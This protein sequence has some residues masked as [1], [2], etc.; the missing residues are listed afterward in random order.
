MLISPTML[1]LLL[2]IGF[3][4]V[5]AVRQSLYSR[6]EGVDESGFV[7]EGDKFVGMV[8][9]TDIF[10]GSTGDAFWNAFYVTTM[11]TVV[12]VVIEVIIGVAMALIMN[13]AFKGRGLIRASILVPWAIPTAVS[14][15]LWQWIFDAN[16]IANQILNTQVLWST[17]GIQAQ[18]AVIIA[19]TWKTAPFIGLLTL[20]G[21]Q[22]IPHEVYEAAKLDGVGAFKQFRHITLPLVKPALMVAILFRILD[23][24]RMFD[25]PYVLIGRGKTSVETLSILAY[26]E[27]S[28][29]DFGPASAYAV[30]LFLY[31]ALVAYAFV[32]LLGADV[33]GDA[34]ETKKVAKA[35]RKRVGGVAKGDMP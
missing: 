35:K 11:F 32:K 23:N 12:S 27:T 13:K 1:V 14:A 24:L 17:D 22:V 2:V 15:L 3:P 5:S 30:L 34:A 26:E 16:G 33:I 4:I 18:L 8:N 31:V 29:S 10:S 28:T 21:L 25:L 6:R 9:Y 20:A 7:I 19:D